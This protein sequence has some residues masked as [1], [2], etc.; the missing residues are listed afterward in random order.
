MADGGGDIQA[1]MLRDIWYFAAPA[2]AVKPGAMLSR[3]YLGEPVLLGR[4]DEGEAFAL[5]DICP[6]RG[7][8]LS[9]GRFDGREVECCYHG[10]RFDKAGSCTA[11]PSLVE[12]QKF[13]PGRM[14]VARY[15]LR[16]SQ[17]LLWIWLGRA[18]PDID[19][20]RIAG[21]PEDARPQLVERFDFPCFIDHAVIGLMDP[22]H[23]PYVHRSWWW[24]SERSMHEKAK[25]F[26]PTERGFAMLR[27]SPS[28][29]S[30]AYKLLGGKPET[31]IRFQLPGVRIE[32]I[33]VGRNRVCNLTAVTPLSATET[34]VTHAMYW[35]MGWPRLVKPLV[36]RFVRRFLGQDRDVVVLQQQGLKYDPALTLI[37][38]ADTQA[39]WYYRLKRE[40]VA[41]RAEARDFA[42]PVPEKVLRWRS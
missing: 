35:T 21:F 20:P 9:C 32:E 25:A 22:A 41:A 3:R 18:E 4:T 36:R 30:F 19:P 2:A 34:E 10:W 8:P 6:H 28:K 24:R 23:G 40:H 31:E 13:E 17:G 5:R 42:N 16:E 14:K 15:P 29:N 27:H 37:P 26:G 12:G 38:D 39:I 7:I 1:T 11:I 33:Q